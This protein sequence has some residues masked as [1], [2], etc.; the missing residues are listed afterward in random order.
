MYLEFFGLREKPFNVTPDPHFLYMSPSHQE[1]FANLLYGVRERKGFILV[2]GEVGTGK[3]T[4][5]HSLLASLDTDIR[6][7]FVYHTGMDFTDLLETIHHEL[8]IPMTAVTRASLLQSLSRYV[9]DEL[10]AGRNLALIIDEAQNLSPEILENLRLL[11]NLETA[12]DKL[13]QIVLVGQPELDEK[14][15]L[16]QLRQLKQRI[17]VHGV[18]HALSPTESRA[19][20][21]HRL[22]VAGAPNQGAGIFSEEAISHIVH[23]AGGI[24]RQLNLLCDNALLIAYADGSREVLSGHAREAIRDHGVATPS[25]RRRLSESPA[26]VV[27]APPAE[28]LHLPRGRLVALAALVLV[29]IAAIYASYRFGARDAA[30]ALVP[31]QITAP[32]PTSTSPA[33]PTQTLAAADSSGEAPAAARPVPEPSPSEPAGPVA[34]PRE[35]AA[36][37]P[38]RPDSARRTPQSRAEP[39]TAPAASLP[40]ELSP[41][42]VTRAAATDS[43]PASTLDAPPP[44]A[45]PAAPP[46]GDSLAAL[47]AD[48]GIRIPRE[49][50][51]PAQPSEA[52]AEPVGSPAPLGAG[53]GAPGPDLLAEFWR[54]G[55]LVDLQAVLDRAPRRAYTVRSGDHFI[56]VVY[57]ATGRQDILVLDLIER[58]NPHISNFDLI[59]P[60]WVLY[61]PDFSE[62]E[63]GP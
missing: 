47:P 26:A 37:F 41:A 2:T 13:L 54:A 9:I 63:P 35:S 51:A 20:V 25:A 5:L 21:R 59:Q 29:L 38:V 10:G 62:H 16:P 53:Q 57:A 43:P 46:A 55:N 49:L 40:G 48:A 60:G 4:L 32:P 36:R 33:A 39:Q 23:A 50:G 14:M 45:P 34:R 12:K 3:T 30:P 18:I 28:A 8:G 17:A 1:A 44:A 27:A 42:P 7:V 11:S 52:P 58:M 56:A 22:A 15:A 31:T 24:P 61:L 19:Y 6:S